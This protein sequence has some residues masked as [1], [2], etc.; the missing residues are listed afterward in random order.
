MDIRIA[1][2]GDIPGIEALLLQVGEV[3]HQIRPDIF[4]DGCLKYD[5]NALAELLRDGKRPVFVAMD[6]DFVAG[7]CF[8][9]LR[10]YDGTG[11]STCRKEI[12]IDDLCV[13]ENRR[14]QGIA[15]SLYRH[16]LD[17]AKGLGCQFVT[18]NVWCGNDNAMAFYEKMGLRPRNVMM[19]VLC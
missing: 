7:Y 4:R 11:V 8:C 19:E 13:D 18:L 15:T 14:G 1:V 17:Y 5:E 3:H 16:A 10:E 2:E 12:Y 6:G 9:V